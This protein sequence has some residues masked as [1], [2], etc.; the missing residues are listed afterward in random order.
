M[1]PIAVSGDHENN[2][3]QLLP[4]AGS[5]LLTSPWHAGAVGLVIAAAWSS[6]EGLGLA[7]RRHWRGL[8][9]CAQ[10]VQLWATESWSGW[11][12]KGPP[13]SSSS[14]PPALGFSTPTHSLV[15]PAPRCSPAAARSPSTGPSRSR[16]RSAS[17]SATTK[18]VG[19]R[20]WTRGRSATRGCCTSRR[21]PAAPPTAACAPAPAAGGHRRLRHL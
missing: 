21:T 19:I 14:S 6:Q 20:G 2:K 9:L 8:G 3:V 4:S 12:W 7:R 11:G 16:P 17:R 1:Y 5:A 13:R 15:P 10:A 18:C